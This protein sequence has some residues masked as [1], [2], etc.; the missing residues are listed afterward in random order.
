LVG[1]LPANVSIRQHASS[2]RQHTCEL[3]GDLPAELLF[4]FFGLQV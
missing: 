2:I 1:D 4:V 3:V